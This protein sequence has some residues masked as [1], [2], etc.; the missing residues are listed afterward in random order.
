MKGFHPLGRFRP[1]TVVITKDTKKPAP[2]FIT[3][4]GVVYEKTAQ[5]KFQ[6]IL[7]KA[8]G[9]DVEY[10]SYPR[11]T[12]MGDP[13]SPTMRQQLWRIAA[14]PVPIYW[15]GMLYE[16]QVVAEGMPYACGL[17]GA[18]VR[19][20]WNRGMLDVDKETRFITPSKR[21]AVFVVESEH[22]HEALRWKA[23]QELNDEVAAA[24][25]AYKAN[26]TEVPEPY[27]HVRVKDVAP[28]MREILA[29]SENTGAP[30]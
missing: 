27:A 3:R 18:S 5:S 1:G 12:Q 7:R 20:L 6:E 26:P 9:G 19:C 17:N 11:P 8:R 30:T 22:T 29:R 13:V 14:S 4:N 23:M 10:V 2:D 21:A 15:S 28:R 16:S 24:I 25:A